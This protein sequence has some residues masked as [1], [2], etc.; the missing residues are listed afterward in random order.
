MSEER[1]MVMSLS[2]AQIR[3]AELEEAASEMRKAA[4][5]KDFYRVFGASEI[6]RHVKSDGLYTVVD[7]NAIIEATMAPAVCYRSL[8]DGQVWVR[9]ATEFFDGR[10]VN[11]PVEQIAEVRG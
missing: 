8:F 11:I 6:W 4:K 9:P 10:F 7:Q 3:I 1:K 5:I 2:E